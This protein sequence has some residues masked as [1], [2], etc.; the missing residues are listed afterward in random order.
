MHLDNRDDDRYFQYTTKLALNHKEIEKNSGKIFIHQKK[1]DPKY[2]KENN[3][4]I[5]LN[6]LFNKN[7][8]KYI[9]PTFS[10]TPQSVK[11]A[12]LL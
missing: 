3:L 9:L 6:V 8:R 2:L 11:N 1:N 7:E 4:T 5:A 10:N 12:L